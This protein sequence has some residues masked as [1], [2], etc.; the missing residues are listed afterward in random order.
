M[1]HLLC[2]GDFG[3]NERYRTSDVSTFWS[4]WIYSVPRYTV[5]PRGVIGVMVL[6]LSFHYYSDWSDCSRLCLTVVRLDVLTVYRLVHLL[7]TVEADGT[8][9]VACPSFGQAGCPDRVEGHPCTPILSPAPL[10]KKT[11]YHYKKQRSHMR[12]L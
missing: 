7:P 5:V 11:Q 9:G 6:V 1:Q 8:G 12:I 3:G 4:I 2:C 10:S